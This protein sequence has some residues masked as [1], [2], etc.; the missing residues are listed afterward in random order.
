MD[1]CEGRTAAAPRSVTADELALHGP[2]AA[3]PWV[4]V[5]GVVYDCSDFLDVHPGG[6]AILLASCGG[7]ATAEF[8]RAHRWICADSLLGAFAIGRFVRAP[9]RRP[10]P[11]RRVGGA[12]RAASDDVRDALLALSISP[13]SVPGASRVLDSLS[14]V[15]PLPERPPGAAR[16]APPTDAGELSDNEPAELAAL[17][18][19]LP[20]GEG[21]GAAGTAVKALL[22]TLAGGQRRVPAR[23]AQKLA[24][25]GPDVSEDAFVGIVRALTDVA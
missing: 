4:V 1:F 24:A 16:L 6:R 20:R 3:S 23:A 10:V 2:T 21:G 9:P 11:P 18:A 7:D 19:T 25:A 5:D 12:S 8:Q 14:G 13:D 22:G 17:W 15:S